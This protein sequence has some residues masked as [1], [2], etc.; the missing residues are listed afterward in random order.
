MEKLVTKEQ[1]RE[2]PDLFKVLHIKE[3]RA[4]FV[5]L[6]GE[7]SVVEKLPKYRVLKLMTTLVTS[8]SPMDAADVSAAEIAEI[9]SVVSKR[10]DDPRWLNEALGNLGLT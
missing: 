4:E 8:D 1:Y 6:G 2:N 10:I 9:S 5:R 7:S 3:L